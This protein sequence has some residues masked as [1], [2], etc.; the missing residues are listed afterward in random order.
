M[1][2][3]KWKLILGIAIS[4]IFLYFAFRNVDP[5]ELLLAFKSADYIYVIPA[6]ALVM[7]SIWFRAMRWQHLMNP[8][9]RI[10][11]LSLFS[12]AS[13]GFMANTVLPARLGEFIRAY[14]IGKK[15]NISKS[16][17][18]ATVV[19]ARI[20]DGM[21]VL[22]FFAITL[23]RFS[24]SYP[25]WLR[26]IVYIAFAFY[27]FALAFI[28]SLRL[29]TDQAT[30]LATFLLKPFPG[31]VSS[32]ITGWMHSFIDG[33]GIIRDFRSVIMASFYSVLIWLP[34]AL[35]IYILVRSFGIEIPL[36]GAFLMLVIYTFG[37]MIPSAPAF[38]GTI[39][40]CS[41]A[42]LSLFSV[43]RADALSFSV[44]YHLVSF[45]PITITGF[46]FLIIEGYSLVELRESADGAIDD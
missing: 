31:K 21:T 27:F 5:H 20:F 25:D 36:S 44:I 15:E 35:V 13:I 29:R 32:L 14:V 41:V 19:V 39:Q 9:K 18:F 24:H 10:G 40:F 28:I 43:S 42:G 45:L 2:S 37:T 22:L 16:S 8:I 38:V 7:I 12:A 30:R 34:N 6:I 23:I 17:A 11:L 46:I 26:N 1:K 3:M 33:L 4:V